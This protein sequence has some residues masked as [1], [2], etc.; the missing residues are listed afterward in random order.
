MPGRLT[1]LWLVAVLV[2]GVMFGLVIAVLFGVVR[3]VGIGWSDALDNWVDNFDGAAYALQLA[4]QHC[5]VSQTEQL[6]LLGSAT[7]LAD[8]TNSIQDFKHALHI[9]VAIAGVLAGLVVFRAVRRTAAVYK[10]VPWCIVPACHTSAM[11][12]C[13]TVWTRHTAA[14]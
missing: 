5:N 9:S 13:R 10:Q 12:H 3:G 14:I 1:A 8:T 7:Y 4:A 11:V 6:T 2:A